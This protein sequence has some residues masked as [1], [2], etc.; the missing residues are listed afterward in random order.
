[1]S[2]TEPAGFTAGGAAA[3]VK[4]DGA[5]DV[6]IVA[7]AEPA[8]A[9]AVFT[10]NRAAAAP[11]TLSRRH[12]NESSL[13]SVIVANSGCANAG[14]GVQGDQA[15]SAMAQ[16]AARLAGCPVDQVLVASTGPI[17][18][19][20]P[21]DLVLAGIRAAHGSRTSGREGGARA[22]AAILTTDDTTKE[23]SVLGAGYTIGGMAKGAG[24][25]RPDMA[26]M[27]A[28]LTTDAAVG[29]G[30]LRSALLQAVDRSFH[31]LTIDGCNSTNDMVAVLA[32][33]A[34]GVTPD[35]RS[36]TEGLTAAC[37][38]LSRLMA[39][40]AEGSSRVV[41]ISVTGAAT[42]DEARRAGR[43]IADSA[44]VRS[45]FYG[46]DPNWGRILGALGAAP[47]PFDPGALDVAYQQVFVA[48]SGVAVAHDAVALRERMISGD[49]DVEVVIGDGTG[50]A[51]VL[52]T[53]L[54]PEYVT[55]N[56]EPS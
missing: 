34:S 24:M 16:T 18:P 53:D 3:G 12:L 47:I 11:V 26:T 50:E 4:P 33:G 29:P 8:Q 45:S 6:A 2:V 55:L 27:L 15:A 40:D 14:T 51:V 42:D 52:T 41:M 38:E 22:A 49:I 21:V 44:L 23:V 19:Q 54:T 39:K 32:S 1:M 48:E 7:A 9:A 36:F 31:S 20:L 28:F 37:T 56:G 5:L 13:V 43:A 30:T 10:V 35:A 17:G 46:G 25:V